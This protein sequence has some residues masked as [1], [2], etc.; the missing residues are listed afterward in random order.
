MDWIALAVDKVRWRALVNAVMDLWI[1]DNARNF[2]LAEIRLAFQKGLCPMELWIRGSIVSSMTVL[3]NERSGFGKKKIQ[4]QTGDFFF[5]IK[6]KP[7]L[8]PTH[9]PN[10][11]VMKLTTQP[12]FSA[13]FKNEWNNTSTLLSVLSCNIRFTRLIWNSCKC[14]T[15]LHVEKNIIRI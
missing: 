8:G 1:P 15:N 13:E 7:T 2:W 11:R 12:P 5:S 3:R 9:S 6:Y 10:E 14:A 4:V